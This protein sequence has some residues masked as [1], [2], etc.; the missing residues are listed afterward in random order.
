VLVEINQ[1]SKQQAALQQ[2]QAQGAAL[3]NATGPQYV[4]LKD[5]LETWR[6][7]VPNE[8]DDLTVW[9]DLLQWRNHM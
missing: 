7:R 8:W 2:A 1:S 9:N 6:L 4:E 5:T 3:P